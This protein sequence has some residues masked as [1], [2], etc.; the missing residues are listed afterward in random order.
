MSH[1]C[2]PFFFSLLFINLPPKNRKPPNSRL[3]TKAMANQSGPTTFT[4]KLASCMNN[5]QHGSTAKT[6]FLADENPADFFSLL[7]NFFEQYQPAFDHDAAL[8][9]RAVHDLWILLRRERT[10]DAYE[11][12]L[13]TRKPDPTYWVQP[14]LHEMHL[15]DRYKTEAARAHTRSLKNLQTIQKMARDEERWQQQLI[16]EKQ[17]LAIQVERWELTRIKEAPKKMMAENIAEAMKLATENQDVQVDEHGP[18]IP[19]AVFVVTERDG[20]QHVG[21]V[22]TNDAVHRIIGMANQYPQPP[23]EVV[24]TYV[25]GGPVPPAYHWLTT[26]DWQRTANDLELRKTLSFDEWRKLAANE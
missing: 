1:N 6:L 12:A 17:K 22:P 7:E 5:L 16:N 15:F 14:D 19:Q 20:S 9:T 13:H 10:I 25:F 18:H 2:S 8:V 11:K 26:E 3:E 4:G 24:R 21:I 23:I